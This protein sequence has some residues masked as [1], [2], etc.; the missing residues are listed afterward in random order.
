MTAG[1]KIDPDT[2]YDDGVLVTILGIASATLV[3]ARR[4]GRL[5][6]CRVGN[7]ALYL[8]KWILDWLDTT[9]VQGLVRQAEDARRQHEDPSATEGHAD[10]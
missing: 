8:G 5:S 7:R 1:M 10:E 4:Q 2:I 9:Q 3:R 6:Y